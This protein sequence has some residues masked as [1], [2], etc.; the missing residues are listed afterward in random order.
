MTTI[1][2]FLPYA[3]GSPASGRLVI[4][5]K[6]FVVSSVTV[7]GGELEFEIVNGNVTLSLYSNANALPT[8]SYYNAKYELE[9]GA[10]Y[11]EQWIVPNTPTA[12]LGQV[13]VSFP[14][15]PSVII[16]PLQL[17]SLGG[18]PGMFLMWDGNKWVPGYPSTFNMNP[19]YISVAAGGSGTDVNIVGSPVALGNLVTINVPDAS[20]TARGVVTTAAQTFAG[21]KTF[22]GNVSMGNLTVTGT[23]TLPPNSYVPVARRVIAGTG[24]T[25]GGALTADVTLNAPVMIASGSGHAAGIA[26]DPG[27]TAGATR[28]LREDAT[29]AVINASSI[30]VVPTTRQVLAGPG[31]S[32]G[33]SLAT[34]VTLSAPVMV[35]SGASHAAGLAPDPG[36]TAGVTRY[37]R[38]DGTWA[39]PPGGTNSPLT[40]KGDLYVYTTI[41]A[42]LPVGSDGYVLTAD[43]TQ[44]SGMK[45]AVAAGGFVDPTTTK[46]DLIARGA[47]APATRLPVG[48][49]GLV[50]TADSTQPLGVRWVAVGGGAGNVTTVFGRTGAV[51][52]VTGDYTAAQ[53]TNA[54][55]TTQAYANPAWLISLAWSKIT[56][57]P[58]TGVSTVFGRSGAVVAAVGDYT[59]AQVTNAV[60][61][62]QTYPNPAWIP[63]YAWSKITGAPAT[64]PPTRQ[65]LAG[66]GLSGGGALSADVTL[67]AVPMG[68]SG[69]SHAA[70]MVPD[71]GATAGTTRFLREDASWAVP[72]G[73]AG[74]QTPWLSNIDGGLFNLSRVSY[75]AIT[76]GTATTPGG[77]PALY[78][79][80]YDNSKLEGML[81][82]SAAANAI[83]TG[84]IA[85]D[86][87]IRANQPGN[88]LWFAT[89][90]GTGRMVLT[91]SGNIG[92]GTASPQNLLSV[93]SSSSSVPAN[94]SVTSDGVYGQLIVA[95]YGTSTLGGI[96]TGVSARGT[97]AAPTATQAGDIILLVQGNGYSNAVATAGSIRISAESAWATNNTPGFISFWTNP[98]NGGV[99]RMRIT[100]AG[101]VGIGTASPALPLHIVSSGYDQAIFEGSTSTGAGLTIKSAVHQ[102]DILTDV[103]SSLF[104]YDRTSNAY[105]LYIDS[106]GR[107]GIGTSGP[108]TKLSVVSSSSIDG[109]TVSSV[110]RASVWFTT[111]GANNRSW[112]LQNAVAAG[113]DFQFLAS[114]APG[115]TPSTMVMTLKAGGNVGIG[116]TVVPV[117]FALSAN[118]NNVVYTSIPTNSVAFFGGLY[119]SAS[120]TIPA[121]LIN[122]GI[123]HNMD[124]GAFI[125]SMYFSNSQAG[126]VIG[127]RHA[128][129][130]QPTVYVRNFQVGINK[131]IAAYALDVSGDCN[132]TGTYRQNGVPI[133]TGG[134]AITTQNT[135][136]GTTL[137]GTYQ[138]TT[139]KPVF[140]TVT[141]AMLSTS[142]ALTAVTDSSSAPSTTVA[143]ATT[144]SGSA[145]NVPISFWVLPNNYYR[146]TSGG[147]LQYWTQWS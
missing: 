68:A 57:A 114:T 69:A 13:R 75:V 107:V 11:V 20:A 98:A 24:M 87:V 119:S 34:D 95:G 140:H 137:G 91:N 131:A 3:D 97:S 32:G 115:G 99:E 1:Q 127:S 37:L 147:T 8:G 48:T 105:R 129:G 43:S 73:G 33:G 101:L 77:A 71:P 41:N 89:P 65:I 80:R 6:S 146:V 143:N 30:G 29:W 53:V 104:I 128:A 112:L 96:L 118:G 103:N 36:V 26:P 61:T 4:Y 40:T 16:S 54:V 117:R 49:D 113:D 123:D 72:A 84:S 51:V 59:A 9:N 135:N 7:A 93:Y 142:G 19:N 92:I 145:I 108:V 82:V 14:P 35:A 27:A 58:A 134:G 56:G 47:A 106:T 2:D 23:V 81:A 39:V 67:A 22:T 122:I 45:W 5:W 111:T 121:A 63:S 64:V 79:G 31:L 44:A 76:T 109:V 21:A 15:S 62:T 18:Q 25:G 88:N 55:D 17:S 60:D 38:E 136:P 90:D 110:D 78:M 138:N 130:H 28:F 50:L 139:G 74:S 144:S 46:G 125:G 42:R 133:S 124:Y 126:C 100:S 132:I 70:G 12:T 141:V 86:F 66:A 83:A 85:G 116:T 52:Q 102:F 94:A 10:V 120:D